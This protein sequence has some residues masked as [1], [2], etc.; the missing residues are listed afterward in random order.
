MD[1]KVVER[2]GIRRRGQTKTGIEFASQWTEAEEQCRPR[3]VVDRISFK[4][5][6]RVP[7]IA[8]RVATKAQHGL[9]VGQLDHH[10]ATVAAAPGLLPEHESW[11]ILGRFEVGHGFV[12]RPWKIANET[13][14][15]ECDLS[16]DGTRS[17]DF[18]LA[19]LGNLDRIAVRTITYR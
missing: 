13:A 16:R 19:V 14:R 6:V 2:I 7:H 15:C 5:F 3:R 8:R 11:E 4:W 12:I 1:S 9:A 17:R 18:Y 10:V